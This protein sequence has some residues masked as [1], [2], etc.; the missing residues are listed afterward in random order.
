[1]K[2]RMA[3][4]LPLLLLLCINVVGSFRTPFLVYADNGKQ[5]NGDYAIVDSFQEGFENETDNWRSIHI[6]KCDV[7]HFGRITSPNLV[8]EG[9]SSLVISV[10]AKGQRKSAVCRYLYDFTEEDF[11]V[12]LKKNTEFIFAWYIPSKYFS[13]AGTFIKFN[14]GKVGYYVSLFYGKTQNETSSF[15][16]LFNEPEKAWI[17]HQRDVYNDYEK[18]WGAAG[19]ISITGL[20]L[21]LADTYG[22]G[23]SQTMYYDSFCIG[24]G[25]DVP[26]EI[27][28]SATPRTNTIY[29]GEVATYYI[30]VTST[31][32][33]EEEIMLSVSD[34]PEGTIG[35]LKP[36]A[37]NPPFQSTLLIN[38]GDDTPPGTFIL[39]ISAK[40]SDRLS[41]LNVTLNI[42][43]SQEPK[44]ILTINPK[45]QVITPGKSANYDISI[46]L[47]SEINTSLYFSVGGLPDNSTALFSNNPIHVTQKNQSKI[48]MTVLTGYLAPPGTYELIVRSQSSMDYASTYSMNTLLIISGA[49]F[50]IR[51]STDRQSYGLGGETVY[52]NG[53]V[54]NT[55]TTALYN[56]SIS[57]QVLNQLNDTVHV[58]SKF[59]DSSGNFADSFK[60]G[61]NFVPG[62][63]LVFVTASKQGFIDAYSQCS[64]VVGESKIPSVT[65]TEIYSADSND[66]EKTVF[67][68]GETASI[69]LRVANGGAD[70]DEGMI[71]IQV[72]DPNGIPLQVISIQM[73]IQNTVKDSKGPI[74]IRSNFKISETA[75]LG[76]YVMNSYVSEKMISQ[77]GKFLT[78][79]QGKFRVE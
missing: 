39:M 25:C 60:I 22:T 40:Y 47:S 23:S 36:E 54:S 4:A 57:I 49:S 79:L 52:L 77:G 32:D 44:L 65:I 6:G 43:R 58:R 41:V 30:N 67:R 42:R 20:G 15:T 45:T 76:D 75:S 5:S 27:D 62:K 50:N 2:A 16:Y 59:T 31:S 17:L 37:G 34:F 55:E 1:M 3:L 35:I 24:I 69:A 72:E 53:N 56:V 21:I 66:T 73:R 28:L 11:V 10:E 26:K 63:Y 68:A 12:P 33:S 51:V 13:Y 9:K 8:Y 70:L 18:I 29:P 71:W 48:L 7:I 78:H 14:N 74:I 19:N 61:E 46:S 64:F 38:S